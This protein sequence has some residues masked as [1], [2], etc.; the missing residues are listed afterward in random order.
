M[1][2]KS[3]L[4]SALLVAVLGSGVAHGQT[5][6]SPY[7]PGFGTGLGGQPPYTPNNPLDEPYNR[8]VE[9]DPNRTKPT[10]DPPGR[11]SQ[12][13]LGHP[14]TPCCLGPIGGDGPMRYDTNCSRAS[15]PRSRSATARWP[16]RCRRAWRWR[17]AAATCSTTPT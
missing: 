1:S 4:C 6:P 14:Y 8:N 16:A 5:P 15:A 3:V 2:A 12:W 10:Q 7:K 17:R 11:L 9:D 13:I